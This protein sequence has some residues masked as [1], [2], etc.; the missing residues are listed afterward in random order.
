M[1]QL[2]GQ[3]EKWATENEIVGWH[4][5]AY[6]HEFEQALG[7]GDGTTGKPH[8]LQSTWPQRVRHD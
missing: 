2:R 4:H 5:Q 3:E 1:S 6:G 7:V 8:I